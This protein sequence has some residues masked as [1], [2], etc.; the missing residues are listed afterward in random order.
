[1]PPELHRSWNE[2]LSAYDNPDGARAQARAQEGRIGWRLVAYDLPEG[3]PIEWQPYPG[4][5]E[6]GHHDL[7]GDREA[8]KSFL[9]PDFCEE[10]D[11]EAT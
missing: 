7:F 10:I 6:S 1:V 11:N 5:E 4:D 3:G 8:L 2:G 9:D